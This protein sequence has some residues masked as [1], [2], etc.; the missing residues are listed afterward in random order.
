MWLVE[1]MGADAFREKIGEYM[2]VKLRTKVE[3]KVSSHGRQHERYQHGE[4][5]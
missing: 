2:G 1:A 5:I 4:D 3:E